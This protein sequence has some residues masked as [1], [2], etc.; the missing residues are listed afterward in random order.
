MQEDFLHYIWRYQKFNAAALKTVDGMDVSII[1]TGF[2][3]TNAGPDF[4]QAKVK[5]GEVEWAG[6]VEIHIKASDWNRHQHQTDPNYQNVILHVVWKA[7]KAILHPDGTAIPT[8]ELKDKVDLKVI[9]SYRKLIQSPEEIACANQWPEVDDVYKSEMLERVLI[10]RLYDKSEKAKQYFNEVKQNWEEV[11]YFM[12]LSS[13]GFKVNQHPFERLATVLPYSFVK[14]IKHHPELLESVL[15]GAAGFLSQEFVDEYPNQLK[16]DWDFL[17]HKHYDILH[18]TVQKHEWRFL[19]LRPANFPTIRLAQLAQILHHLPSLFDALV[20]EVHAESLLKSLKVN[21]H[22]YWENHFQFDVESGKK[23]KKP[24]R[25]SIE[26]LLLNTVPPL[27]SFYA[28]SVGEEKYIDQAIQLL[29]SLK[30]EKNFISKKY[31]SLGANLKTA[32]DSQA[33]IQL[34][35]TYCQ[36]KKCLSCSIGISIIK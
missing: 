12:L 29:T 7:D 19:R 18:N 24:G 2:A 22:Q 8:I 25:S 15:F 20:L 34:H 33:F 30:P 10:E 1:K 36:P 26:L 5:I 28:K 9:D 32:Y 35:N 27:L 11:C 16:K 3:H 21:P 17:R 13:M 31:D 23:S 4:Q 6:A 14:K